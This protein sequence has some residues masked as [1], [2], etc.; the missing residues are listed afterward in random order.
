MTRAQRQEQS[1]GDILAAAA[2]LI[3]R[4]GYHGL[5][6]RELARTTGQSLANL[7]NYFA[8]KD[9]LLFEVQSRAF[10]TL[11]ET[12]GH[13]VADADTA[14]SRL[15]AFVYNHVRYVCARP[16]VLRVLV[17]EAGALPAGRRRVVRALKERYFAQ[18]LALVQG[19]VAE[20]G[21]PLPE[22]EVERAAYSLFGMLNWVYGWYDPSRHGSAE[23]V[24]R[25]I[26]ALAS[27][28]LV[29]RRPSRR[30]QAATERRVAGAAFVSP[31][32]STA[33]GVTA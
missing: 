10:E 32:R 7:Y 18:G 26:H 27:G 33:K 3:A 5:T 20:A 11:I 19:I 17:Q 31:L 1:R 12:A 24:A 16:D 14:Q 23:D 15:H 4:H 28:G 13:A 22:A 21:T 2:T 30:E 9:D 25:S 8:S 29:A 6:M